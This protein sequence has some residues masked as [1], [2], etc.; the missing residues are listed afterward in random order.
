LPRIMCS[1]TPRY[2]PMV[3]VVAVGAYRVTAGEDRQMKKL[4]SSVPE[5]GVP[6]VATVTPFDANGIDVGA[7]G[8][9]VKWLWH[10]GVRT[11]LVNGTTGEFFATSA[12][13]RLEMLVHCRRSFPGTVVAQV[14]CT[15]ATD[16]VAALE[17]VTPH[18]DCLAV[19]APYYYADPP[20]DGL[21]EYFAEILSHAEIPV[22][23]YNF[24]RHTQ[25][26]ISPNILARLSAK[27]PQLVGI[28]DSGRDRN[29][30]RG[31]VETGLRV[32][33]GNDAMAARVDEFG[34]HGIVTGGGNPLAEVAVGIADALSEHDAARA[35]RLQG[36]FDR[37]STARRSWSLSEIAIVKAGLG[38]RIAGFPTLTR[39][40]LLG[41]TVAEAH[42]IREF[43]RRDILSKMENPGR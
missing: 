29:V 3:C 37:W 40:P 17:Q 7:V 35:A 43:L 30:T 13:E 21:S 31:Y 9:Y 15:S 34:V 1:V 12:A 8:E 10:Q 25:A 41:A 16:T 27:F 39:V 2:A 6:I 20:E 24:P 14:G 18:A 26:P 4:H 22:L 38:E 28:K 5:F 33:V 42:A 11:I 19:I 23:L 32:F 36:L